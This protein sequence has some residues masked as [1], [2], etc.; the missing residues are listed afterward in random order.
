MNSDLFQMIT[1]LI[2]MNSYLNEMNSYLFQEIYNLLKGYCYNFLH[3]KY[4]PTDAM[5]AGL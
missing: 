1:Y 4:L 5:C 3:I 2:Q